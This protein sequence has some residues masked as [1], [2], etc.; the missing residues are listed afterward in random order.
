MLDV[1]TCVMAVLD[2]VVLAQLIQHVHADLI[3]IH[4]TR[5]LEVSEGLTVLA[6]SLAPHD[7]WCKT[8]RHITHHEHVVR[9]HSDLFIAALPII[10]Y[11]KI[12]VS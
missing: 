11:N 2:V 6:G 8:H 12:T 9:V 4:L 10:C 1:L 5:P 3:M 7:V